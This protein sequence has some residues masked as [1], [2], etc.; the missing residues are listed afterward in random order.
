MTKLNKL[1]KSMLKRLTIFSNTG[2][3]D[4]AGGG[5]R[6]HS[7]YGKTAAIVAVRMSSGP[8]SESS[9]DPTKF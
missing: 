9:S 3:G 1:Q 4:K 2:F 8:R 7:T 6:K 5:S